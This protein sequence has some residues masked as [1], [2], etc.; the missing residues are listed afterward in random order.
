MGRAL[1]NARGGIARF[2][3]PT[4]LALLPEGSKNRVLRAIEGAPPRT[5][6]ERIGRSVL[7][8]LASMMIA[9]TIEIDDAVRSAAH[10]QLVI[11]GSGLDGRAWR[12]PELKETVV[13]EVDHP[14]TQREKQS[15][16]AS[17]KPTAREVRFVAVDFARDDLY[18]ALS[19][20]GHDPSLPTTWIWEGVVMY[21]TLHDIEATLA[22]I[23]RRSAP[24]SR[25]LVAYHT[26]TRL[27]FLVGYWLRRMGE[28][29]RSSFK[30]DEMRTL[31]LRYGFEVQRDLRLDD[32][33]AALSSEV[34]R[35]TRRMR[36]HRFATARRV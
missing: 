30:V 32:I 18:E 10:P 2:S 1:A 19:A 28:P 31:L 24:Q 5:L 16:S 35:A 6:R 12:M 14:S 34:G 13:F 23:E 36:H 17:L 29:L 4:A 15:R 3:D 22:V 33:G 7:E 21:L 25:L 8:R 27:L 26:P 20:A 11:L 9:R